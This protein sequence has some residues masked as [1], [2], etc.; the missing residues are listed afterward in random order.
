MIT[1][2]QLS[3]ELLSI[4]ILTGFHFYIHAFTYIWVLKTNLLINN[5]A[6]ANA[7]ATRSSSTMK[8]KMATPIKVR[9]CIVTPC[10]VSPLAVGTRKYMNVYE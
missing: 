1:D 4:Y 2:K 10:G 7:I 3:I 9:G 5:P 6:D 8:T